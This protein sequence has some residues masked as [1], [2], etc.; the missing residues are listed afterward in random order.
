MWVC[1][2]VSVW[3]CV[4]VGVS[5]C[6]WV[7]MWVCGCVWVCECVSVC[8]RQRECVN[9]NVCFGFLGAWTACTFIKNH[10]IGGLS[11]AIGTGTCLQL[12]ANWRPPAR[13][14]LSLLIWKQ[15]FYFV[16]KQVRVAN[17]S[18]E[19][20]Q[21]ALVVCQCLY[22]MWKEF[23]I[24]GWGIFN[25]VYLLIKNFSQFFLVRQMAL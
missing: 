24:W 8:V 13:C 14:K 6:E 10:A 3:V 15:I 18:K 4:C 12:F 23:G 20:Q 7:S 21:M 25:V 17:I 9:V 16:N 19:N 2:C 5:M 22:S 1:V 11:F